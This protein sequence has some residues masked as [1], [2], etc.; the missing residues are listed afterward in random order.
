MK[1]STCLL[2]PSLAL[3]AYFSP[4]EYESGKVHMDSMARKRNEWAR[5]KAAGDFDSWKWPSWDKIRHR[6]G[7]KY[8]GDYVKCTNGQAVVEQ[9]NPNQT[10]A[11]QNVSL[12]AASNQLAADTPPD[13]YVR[14]QITC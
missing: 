8:K 1:L 3:A 2:L 4:Q 5:H 7:P 13:R 12:S 14:L 6:G 11:C 10:F 9:G